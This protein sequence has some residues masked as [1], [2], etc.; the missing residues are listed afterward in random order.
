MHIH[1]YTSFFFCLRVC[2]ACYACVIV[3]VSLSNNLQFPYEHTYKIAAI[4]SWPLPNV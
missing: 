1:M 3:C 4:I 2:F